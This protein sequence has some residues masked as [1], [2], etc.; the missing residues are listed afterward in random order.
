MKQSPEQIKTE[1]QLFMK[2]IQARINLKIAELIYST[3]ETKEIYRQKVVESDSYSELDELV[4]II[5]DGEY[6]LQMIQ[7]KLF[8]Q[9]RSYIWKIHELDYLPLKEKAFWT[10]QLIKAELA[11]EMTTVYCKALDAERAAKNSRT[12]GWTIIRDNQ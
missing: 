1:D 5:D 3:E 10:E 4:R 8:E 12:N 2:K 7:Q 9:L 11:E 6:Q